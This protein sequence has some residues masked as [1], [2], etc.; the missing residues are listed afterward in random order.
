MKFGKKTPTIN[1]TKGPYKEMLPAEGRTFCCAAATNQADPSNAQGLPMSDFIRLPS[2]DDQA[3][4][5]RSRLAALQQMERH[6]IQTAEAVQKLASSP[7]WI[8]PYRFEA[9]KTGLPGRDDS[10]R[11]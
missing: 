7:T 11:S 6:L 3:Y 5:I 4:Q 2:L 1:C 8:N 9:Q 10:D